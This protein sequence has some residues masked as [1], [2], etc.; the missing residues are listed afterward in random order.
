MSLSSASQIVMTS[1]LS[2]RRKL[3]VREKSRQ[4]MRYVHEQRAARTLSIVVGAFILCW[5][6]FFAFSP[7]TAF[8]ESVS[9]AGTRNRNKS[10]MFFS[11]SPTK[12]PS[13]PL[14][15]GRA[16]WT[17]CSTPWSIPASPEIL[18]ELSNKSSRANANKKSKLHL[19]L[20]CHLC[21]LNSFLSHRCGSSRQ[22]LQL[23]RFFILSFL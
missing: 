23:N 20:H 8:C 3:N 17:R 15:H 4:M 19:K 9:C 1:P 6:P 7:L 16:I 11:A 22:T 14:L 12:R 21:S 13:S 10:Y 2:T 18:E 5:T